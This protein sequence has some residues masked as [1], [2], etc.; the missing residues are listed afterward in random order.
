MRY[1]FVALSILVTGFMLGYI[2][3]HWNIMTPDGIP[4]L[5]LIMILL[6]AI[7]FLLM[8]IVEFLH[9]RLIDNLPEEIKLY[10]QIKDD[11]YL[12]L[13]VLHELKKDNVITDPEFEAEKKKIISK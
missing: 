6:W 8:I 13:A 10:R 11:R 3:S 5:H 9:K 4:N 1:F 2:A 12:R 7:L